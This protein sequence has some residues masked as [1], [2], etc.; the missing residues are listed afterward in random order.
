M[1][2]S[3]AVALVLSIPCIIDS[4]SIRASGSIYPDAYARDVSIHRLIRDRR[5]ALRMSEEALASAVGV[6]RSAVQQWEREG[7]RGTTPRPSK[8]A[9]IAEVLGVSVEQ[10]ARAESS[11]LSAGKCPPAYDVS[12][13]SGVPHD[14]RHL[15][16][17]TPPTFT[18]ESVVSSRELPPQ[19]C[20]AVPDDALA[21]RTPRGTVL[22]FET[23]AKPQPGDGVPVEDRYGGRHVRRYLPG[24]GGNWTAG[25]HNDAY[26]ELQ[27]ERDGLEILAAA[28]GRM[29]GAV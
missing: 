17:D 7:E 18:W 4:L 27:A 14:M 12:R 20:L 10:L 21:P 8:R 2:R 28:S 24:V 25:V 11:P 1:A 15:P 29:S 16:F 26:P 6:S 22:I 23:A 5:L 3:M 9:K 13:D 19:F